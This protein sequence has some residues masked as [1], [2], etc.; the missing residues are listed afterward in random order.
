[1]TRHFYGNTAAGTT[2]LASAIDGS[3]TTATLT[4]YSGFP[5]QYPYWAMID[6]G[7][8][9]AEVVLVTGVS[10]STATLVRAQDGTMA[11]GHNGGAG[12]EHIIPAGFANDTE[13]HIEASADVHGLTGGAGVVGTTSPQTV[14]NKTISASIITLTHTAAPA[15]AQLIRLS[16]DNNAGRDGLVWDNTGGSTGR[17]L[18]ARVAGVDKF[19]VGPDGKTT[20]NSATGTDKVLSV[21]EDG[22]ERG[23]VKAD[24]SVEHGLMA[25][26]TTTDR[27]LIR[28][29]PTQRAIVV[30]NE[31]D[32]D[33]FT[34]SSTGNASVAGPLAVAGAVSAN[35][36]L[37][38]AGTS[39][40]TGDVTLPVPAAGTTPRLTV[41]GRTGSR[42]WEGRDQA[43]T[44]TSY[45]TETGSG[46]LKDKLYVYNGMPVVAL[47]NNLTD[48]PNPTDAMV[49][50]VNSD[51]LIYQYQQSTGTWQP[52]MSW[53]TPAP[54]VV[55]AQAN[56]DL[57]L[58][59]GVADIPGTTISIT[60]TQPNIV[61]TIQATYDWR[62]VNTGTGY[63]YGEIAVNNTTMGRRALFTAQDVET[64]LTG[65]FHY[66][67]V[68]GAAGTHTIKLQGHKDINAGTAVFAGGG[69]TGL[70]VN[71]YDW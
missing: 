2:Q 33:V 50:L 42:V 13:A 28:V 36:T 49:V 39:I 60:T 69:T 58:G 24:G 40:L 43:D 8:A 51:K 37:A 12:F 55:E 63:C 70:L 10:G 65:G 48:V 71:V 59:T 1:M 14:S 22:T 23:F 7:T 66:R 9:S 3:A 11:S 57:T 53:T 4:G 18:V 46:V 56:G 31:L 19:T 15:G 29:R 54:R 20:L 62:L 41:K 61:T 16:A 27:I 21:A 47:V 45:L 34:V 64:R 32:T 5:T 25:A 38:V 6:R 17:A 52:M 26:D 68:L 44:V 30:K 67:F 35:N